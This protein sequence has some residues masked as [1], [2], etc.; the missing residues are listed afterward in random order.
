MAWI[1]K[2]VHDLRHK[3]PKQEE[4][5]FPLNNYFLLY[6]CF[7]GI[8]PLTPPLGSSTSPFL[9]GINGLMASLPILEKIYFFI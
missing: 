5:K 1:R 4:V 8:T 6:F 3:K 2:I 7:S 9:L